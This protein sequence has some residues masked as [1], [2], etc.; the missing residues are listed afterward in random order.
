MNVK[1]HNDSHEADTALVFGK[2]VFF[3]FGGILALMLGLY[4]YRFGITTSTSQSNWGTF[5]D[6][7]GGTLNPL[8]SFLTLIVAV[9]VWRLQ[10]RELEDTRAA[11]EIQGKSAETQ[12][13]EQRFY[14]LLNLYR[15]TLESVE[16]QYSTDTE[17]RVFNGK[18]AFRQFTA[19]RYSNP[20]NTVGMLCGN[21]YSNGIPAGSIEAAKITWLEESRILDHYFRV[22]FSILR[23]AE[24]TLGS[25]K[26]RYVKLFRAQLSSDEVCLIAANLLFDEEGIKMR[27]LVSQYGILKHLPKCPLRELAERTLAPKSFGNRWFAKN[28]SNV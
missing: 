17:R 25:E 5:G 8:V 9:N 7:L 4:V 27:D 14:D 24:P 13:K 28:S 20:L 22:A 2:F 23:E 19:N 26:F 3:S 21:E 12:R 1:K 16:H 10:K 18:Q 11:L 15:S 6:F